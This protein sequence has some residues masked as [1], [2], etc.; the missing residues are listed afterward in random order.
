MSSKSMLFHLDQ[1]VAHFFDE[2]PQKNYF[3]LFWSYLYSASVENH[4]R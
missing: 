1:G 4:H 2:G 3:R